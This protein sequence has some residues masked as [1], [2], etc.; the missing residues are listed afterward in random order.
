MGCLRA[1]RPRLRFGLVVWVWLCA[2]GL[3]SGQAPVL[4]GAIEQALD[5]KTNLAIQ[6]KPITR[7]FELIS[8]HTGL[9]IVVPPSTLQLLPYGPETVVTVTIRD[10]SLR[11]GLARMLRPIG[12]TLVVRNEHIEILPTPPLRRLGRRPSRDE[13]ERLEQL[14]T[15]AWKPSVANSLP[16]QFQVPEPAGARPALLA[17]AAKVGAG[18]AGEVLEVATRTLGWTWFPSGEQIVVLTF[19]QQ[20]ERQLD[21]HVAGRYV[22]QPVGKILT[23]LARQ[24]DMTISFEP[25]VMALLPTEARENFSLLAEGVTMTEALNQITGATGLTYAVEVDGLHVYASPQLR[26][27][28]APTPADP[29]VANILVPLGDDGTL[30]EIPI[31]RSELTPELRTF[32]EARKKEGIDKLTVQLDAAAK[33]E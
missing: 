20:T 32:I 25:G 2:A 4:R 33:N 27:A 31:R 23:D 6:R 8:Q 9:K 29:V 22:K 14:H 24:A 18:S 10:V 19:A 30:V 1:S 13:L 16:L 26:K 17:A 12:M 3:V 5:G 28:P 15:T 7:A 21:R 11:D